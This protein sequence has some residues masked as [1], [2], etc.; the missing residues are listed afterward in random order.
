MSNSRDSIFLL[1]SSSQYFVWL[2]FY[3]LEIRKKKFNM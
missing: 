1:A 3:N 2:Y